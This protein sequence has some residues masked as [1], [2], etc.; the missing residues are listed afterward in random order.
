MA[1][2]TDGTRL[3]GRGDR[4]LRSEIGGDC[5]WNSGHRG[6]VVGKAPVDADGGVG[7][8]TDAC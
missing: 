5:E 2:E 4:L 7:V 6:Q 1:R 8:E 3:P